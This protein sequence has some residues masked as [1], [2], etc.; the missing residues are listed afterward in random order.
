MYFHRELQYHM[1]QLFSSLNKHLRSSPYFHFF[2]SLDSGGLLVRVLVPAFAFTKHGY[3]VNV[4]PYGTV[5]Y[6]LSDN[7]KCL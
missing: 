6:Y 1:M 7:F 2:E 5:S 4:Y 3:S